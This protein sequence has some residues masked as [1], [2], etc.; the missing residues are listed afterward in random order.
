MM[1][2][3]MMIMLRYYTDGHLLARDSQTSPE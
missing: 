2:M 1:M 3:M